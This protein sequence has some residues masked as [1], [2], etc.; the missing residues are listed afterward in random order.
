MPDENKFDVRNELLLMH[1]D[2]VFRRWVVGPGF[3]EKSRN[4]AFEC[5]VSF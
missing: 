3:Y 2:R 4:E 1:V 5:S